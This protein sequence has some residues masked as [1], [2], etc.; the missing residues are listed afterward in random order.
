M[1]AIRGSHPSREMGSVQRKSSIRPRTIPSTAC[2]PISRQS[3]KYDK[4][5][6]P[7]CASRFITLSSW[8]AVKSAEPDESGEVVD[9]EFWSVVGAA[10][11]SAV[12]VSEE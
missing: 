8:M 1:L 11:G 4:A 12:A 9:D 5:R 6:V 10:C 7:G 3:M 2:A